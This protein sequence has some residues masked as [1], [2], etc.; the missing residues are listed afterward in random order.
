VHLNAGKWC[1]RF[2][3]KSLGVFTCEES[4]AWAYDEAVRA[5]YGSKGAVNGVERPT[6]FRERAV[7]AVPKG[8]HPSANGK[9]WQ[10]EV[11]V[12]DK[13]RRRTVDTL[14]EATVLAREWKAEQLRCK[15]QR[16]EASEEQRRKQVIPSDQS[17]CA[18]IPTSSGEH[19]LVSD[20]D[21]DMVACHKWRIVN[22][23]ACSTI[24][25]KTTS[26]SRMLLNA[27]EGMLVDHID[28][29]PMNNQRHNL[30]LVTPA[31]NSHN[32]SMQALSKKTS[33]F[34]GVHWDA[35]AQ[36]WIS[37]LYFKRKLHHVG[38]FTDEEAA[39]K[40]WNRKTKE[41]L[42]VLAFQNVV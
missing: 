15:M 30:R 36:R 29:N 2:R 19:I 4:A 21:I 14:E 37:R 6:N 38:T 13:K 35:S 10:V 1:A 31:E 40:A 5:T 11:K 16:V 26:M 33:R 7:P 18:I 9:R 34:R 12:G 22:G 23:Y 39:A 28:H 24:D 20:S 8:F 41:L 17:G 25:N 32:V 3:R 42:G 27:P